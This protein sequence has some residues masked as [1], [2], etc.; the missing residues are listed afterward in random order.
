MDRAGS[1]NVHLDSDC[2]GIVSD[3]DPA[4]SRGHHRFHAN[5]ADVSYGFQIETD[6]R[7]LQERLRAGFAE[8]RIWRRRIEEAQSDP[9]TPAEL[10]RD[11][12]KLMDRLRGRDCPHCTR[13]F[14]GMD[15]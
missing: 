9:S 1:G 10:R 13:L 8:A 2:R 11:A 14:T 3:R 5:F 4:V 12:Y 15:R 7:A 6:D